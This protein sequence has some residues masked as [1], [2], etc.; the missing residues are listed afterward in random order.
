MGFPAYFNK[1]DSIKSTA[2]KKEAKVF[3]HLCSGALSWKGDFSDADTCLDH[4]GT[5]NK[6]IS[7]T[8]KMC[9]KLVEDSLAMGKL[10]SVLLLDLP[11]YYVVGRVIKKAD[12]E[13]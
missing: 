1:P 6:S 9:D 4:K 8:T 12:I 11:E 10:N 3:R 5:K 7:V 2:N 13:K